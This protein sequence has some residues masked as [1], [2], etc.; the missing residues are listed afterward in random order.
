MQVASTRTAAIARA[1]SPIHVLDGFASG[2]PDTTEV[3]SVRLSRV[4]R[5]GPGFPD[6]AQES[7]IN[8]T[9][10]MLWGVER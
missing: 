2:V 4:A 8:T 6:Q 5:S 9:V 3:T 7:K 10:R 1:S